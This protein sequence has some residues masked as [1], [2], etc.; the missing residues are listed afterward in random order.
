MFVSS[1][2]LIAVKELNSEN[3]SG[4]RTVVSINRVA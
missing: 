1:R 3:A 4:G 2:S